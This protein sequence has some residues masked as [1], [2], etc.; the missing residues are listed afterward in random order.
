[1]NEDDQRGVGIGLS[2]VARF[3]QLHS[4]QAWV[5]ERPGGGASFHVMLPDVVMAAT[6]AAITARRRRDPRPAALGDERSPV[7]S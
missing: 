7:S 5:S 3:T 1:G 2:L 6:P 4:G